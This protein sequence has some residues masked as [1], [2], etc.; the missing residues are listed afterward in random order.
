MR[1]NLPMRVT[2]FVRRAALVAIFAATAGAPIDAWAAPKKAVP[3]VKVDAFRSMVE[4]RLAQIA[5]KITERASK[6]PAPKRDEIKRQAELAVKQVKAAV[7]AAVADG[8]ITKDEAS[9]VRAAAEKLRAILKREL[10]LA[11]AKKTKRSGG[12]RR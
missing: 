8:I 7:D 2:S 11:R 6:L 10:P 3:V 4:R 12:A 9:R 1:S 5:A